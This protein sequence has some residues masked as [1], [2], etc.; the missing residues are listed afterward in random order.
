MDS[1]PV[2]FWKDFCGTGAIYRMCLAGVHSPAS[3]GDLFSIGAFF[4]TAVFSLAVDSS[5]AHFS[6]LLMDSRRSEI[7]SIKLVASRSMG[8]PNIRMAKISNRRNEPAVSMLTPFTERG[9]E[10]QT[11]S[12]PRILIKTRRSIPLYNGLR[13]AN[14]RD[15]ADNRQNLYQHGIPQPHNLLLWREPRPQSNRRGRRQT[16]T[17]RPVIS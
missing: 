5:S 3:F 16:T 2:M 13:D 9:R 8:T 4:S 15:Q 7:V 1:S 12:P 14:E 6:A 17:L 11:T 10:V